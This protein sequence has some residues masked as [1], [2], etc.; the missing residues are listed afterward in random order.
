MTSHVLSE[1]GQCVHCPCARRSQKGHLCP[2]PLK[3]NKT[4]R[5]HLEG[6]QKSLAQ[7]SESCATVC[8]ECL[9][10]QQLFTE[11]STRPGPDQPSFPIQMR[12]GWYDHRPL[13]SLS[14]PIP[15]PSFFPSLRPSSLPILSSFPSPCPHSRSNR[16]LIIRGI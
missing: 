5:D 4:K 12:S 9:L 8:L 7:G 6:R 14:L 15:H 1:C 13:L 10:A 16:P 11:P 2:P 3:K